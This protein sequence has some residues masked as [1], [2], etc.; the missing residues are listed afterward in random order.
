MYWIIPNKRCQHV[1]IGDVNTNEATSDPIRLVQGMTKGSVLGPVLFILYTS[2]LGDLG[3]SHGINYQL[4]A[5]D[6]KIYMSFN[7]GTTRTQSC[8]LSHF[9][10]CIKHTRSWMKTN[11]IKCNDDKTE[12]IILGT[13]HQLTEVNEISIKV[14][15]AVLK[16]VPN[17]RDPGFFLDCL[18]KNGFHINKICGQLYPLLCNIYKMQLHIHMYTTKNNNTSTGS[19][20]TG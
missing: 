5:D 12:F 3:R 6:Q 16:P 15:N 8:C 10:A 2:P 4:F 14:G 19:V 9:E 7:P 13:R 20:K 1:T 17:I 11:L 18:L